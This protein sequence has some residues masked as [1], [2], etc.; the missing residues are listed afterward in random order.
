MSLSSPENVISALPFEPICIRAPDLLNVEGSVR[1]VERLER[2]I[3][4]DSNS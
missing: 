3:V 2:G 4:D 1:G